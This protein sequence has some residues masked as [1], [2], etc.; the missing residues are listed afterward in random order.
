MGLV[1]IELFVLFLQLSPY[2]TNQDLEGIF[3]AFGNNALSVRLIRGQSEP[4]TSRDGPPPF[5]QRI[6]SVVYKSFA[7]AQGAL[8]MDGYELDGRRMIVSSLVLRQ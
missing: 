4:P 2:V 6:A 3:N 8:S 5:R 7:E 1:R